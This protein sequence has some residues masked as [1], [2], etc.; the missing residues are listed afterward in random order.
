MRNNCT[1]SLFTSDSIEFGVHALVTKTEPGDSLSSTFNCNSRPNEGAHQEAQSNRQQETADEGNVQ[2]EEQ[3][4]QD[5]D[6]YK[7]C[8]LDEKAAFHD[9]RFLFAYSRIHSRALSISA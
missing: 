4:Q 7:S 9:D 1:F 3:I 6:A 2:M 8:H 5:Q